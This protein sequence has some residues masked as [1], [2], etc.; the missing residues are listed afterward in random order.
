MRK[1]ILASLV[2]GV[3]LGTAAFCQDIKLPEIAIPNGFG[4]GLSSGERGGDWGISVDVTSPYL[5][6]WGNGELAF[7]AAGD[8]L[9]KEGISPQGYGGHLELVLRGSART[10]YRQSAERLYEAL[11]RAR[12][13]GHFPD[14]RCGI[15]YDSELWHVREFRRRVLPRKVKARLLVSGNWGRVYLQRHRGG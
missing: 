5:R 6:L 14:D 3:I 9:S 2:C 10:G 4:F 1:K 13:F 12:R 8:L 11:W 7:R 15:V